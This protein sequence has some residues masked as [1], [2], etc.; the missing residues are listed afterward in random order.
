M[1]IY[2]PS[3]RQNVVT[4]VFESED[5]RES[6]ATYQKRKRHKPNM[7]GSSDAGST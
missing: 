6:G 3:L 7:R 4:P 1:K 5:N 2:Q